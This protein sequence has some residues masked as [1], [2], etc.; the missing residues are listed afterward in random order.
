[1]GFRR[2]VVPAGSGCLPTEASANGRS[3]ARAGLEVREVADIK[4]A[5]SAALGQ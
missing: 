1:M 2:A 4:E 3:P 5:I